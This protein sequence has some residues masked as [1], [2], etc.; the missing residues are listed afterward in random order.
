MLSCTILIT[1]RQL[2]KT[3]DFFCQ[4]M[5][6]DE[7]GWTL[8]HWSYGEP[9]LLCIYNPTISMNPFL[10]RFK[11]QVVIRHKGDWFFFLSHYQVL[12]KCKELLFYIQNRRRNWYTHTPHDLL[13]PPWLKTVITV[14]LDILSKKW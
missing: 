14:T 4:I 11:P 6:I 5:K 3:K 7:K 12:W 9:V 8:N 1:R 13:Q 10:N 2:V